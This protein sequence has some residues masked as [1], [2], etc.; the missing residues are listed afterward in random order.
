MQADQLL[1]AS[2]RSSATYQMAGPY[3]QLT[4]DATITVNGVSGGSVK[5]AWK[6]IFWQRIT[7][8]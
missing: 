8:P 4:R 3:A 2:S 5:M 6:P 1:A 7:M